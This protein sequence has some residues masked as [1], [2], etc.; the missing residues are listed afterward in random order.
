M[1]N[2]VNNVNKGDDVEKE[3]KTLISEINPDNHDLLFE[4]MNIKI[5]SI[6]NKPPIFVCILAHIDDFEN[7]GRFFQLN[8]FE[9]AKVMLSSIIKNE[10]S[11]E[12]QQEYIN[13]L[14][15]KSVFL[16]EKIIYWLKSDKYN[17]S[18][19]L[20]EIIDYAQSILNKKLKK[21]YSTRKNILE[22]KNAKNIVWIL[23]R[24]SDDKEAFKKYIMSMV[25]EKNVYKFLGL[26][27]TTYIGE[28]ESY[29]FY[30]DSL[31]LLTSQEKVDKII[32]KV[33][34]N[35]NPNQKK[36]KYLYDNYDKDVREYEAINYELL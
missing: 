10:S 21:Y 5:N 2:F 7:K 29:A 33:K 17:I 36:V 28:K 3:F 16:L 14:A 6:D 15:D 35:L 12:Q 20:Q 9:R 19:Q 4:L 18:Q 13:T 11:K 23:Y 8:S 22:L 1:N 26:F 34:Y 30:N 25:N 24:N 31:L 32:K 27:I